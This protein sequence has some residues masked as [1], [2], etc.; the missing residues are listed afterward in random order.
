MTNISEITALI[1]ALRAEQETDAISPESLGS[2]LQRIL[3]LIADNVTDEQLADLQTQV[4]AIRN[5]V[6][7]EK[8]HIECKVYGNKL[9]VKGNIVSLTA[10]GYVPYIFRYSTKRNRHRRDRTRPRTK[11]PILKGWHVYEGT[12]KIKVVQKGEIQIKTDPTPNSPVE[13]DV[14]A[15]S[16]Q[17]LFKTP[18]EWRKSGQDLMSVTYG[19]RQYEFRKS[20]K[21]LRLKFAIAFGLPVEQGKSLKWENIRTN[22]AVIYVNVQFNNNTDQPEFHWST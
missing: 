5:T 12:G 18:R 6:S 1:T 22:L 21:K 11:G 7:D 9:S 8:S 10:K 14:Y 20:R 2:L 4:N 3:N 17:H 19:K 16:P 13:N 15:N